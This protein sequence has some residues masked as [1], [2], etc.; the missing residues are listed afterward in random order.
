MA[1]TYQDYQDPEAVVSAEWLKDHVSDS[2]LRIIDCTTH[3]RPAQPEDGVPYHPEPGR[4][5]Y[6]AG[7][8]PGAV[9]LDLANDLS[10]PDPKLHFMCPDAAHFAG[11]IGALGIG[12]DH[13]VVIY[14]TSHIMWATRLW[15]M[16]RAFGFD[17]A[18]VL[19]GGLK[20]WQAAGGAVSTE[21]GHYPP[22]RFTAKPRPGYFVD[23]AAVKGAIGKDDAVTVNALNPEFHIGETPSRYGRPGRVPGSVNV[24]AAT[25][26][27]DENSRFT[28]LGEARSRFRAAGI[29]PD[30]QVIA[31]CGGGISATVDLFLL[32]QLGFRDLTLYDGSMGEWARDESLPIERG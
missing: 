28:D 20:A 25:L 2:D 8:I 15:W 10:K 30:K 17:N 14:S 4:A 26:L 7:H 1:D 24:P 16:F 18:A 11:T 21:P 32:H 9:F 12:D 29:S 23:A 5:D 13:R 3:L 31:Y 27:D 6:D 19:D 22:A